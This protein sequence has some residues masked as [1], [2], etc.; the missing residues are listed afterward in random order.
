MRA[1]E[2]I[3]PLRERPFRLLLV[4]R[5]TS[6]LGDQIA[7]IAL[8]FAVLDLTGSASD[9]G[10]ALAARTLALVVFVLAG[11]VW[12]DRLSRHRLMMASDLGRLASQGL[13][14]ALLVGGIA[15]IWEV[16]ALQAVNGAATAFFRPAATGLTPATVA[17]HDV[18]RANALLTFTDSASQ[19]LGPVVAGVLVVSLGPGWGIAADAATFAVSALCLGGIR[20]PPRERTGARLSFL[21]DLRG[22]WDAVRSRTWLWLSTLLFAMFQ[23]L[24]LPT[25]FVLGPVISERDLGGAAAWAA[26]TAA[27]GAG[28]VV[29]AIGA[30][31]IRFARPL[32]ACNLTASLVVPAMVFLAAGSSTVVVAAA[33]VGAGI[34]I[35]YA[36]VI[37]ET[38]IQQSVPE[39]VL[40]RVAAYDWMGSTALRPLGY[41]AVGPIAA[42]VGTGA[43]LSFAGALTAALLIG[44]IS[45]PAIRDLRSLPVAT[46][47]TLRPP[48]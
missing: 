12:A 24:V 25:F 45:I 31:A 41:A 7:P 8:A 46:E 36:S 48:P 40:S 44:S 28:A 29:G 39:A 9:L 33:A 11:G 1:R 18:Q 20:L 34:A 16:V 15:R 26:I 4:A 30:M 17:A 23:L 43:T 37:Y 3:G 22:G 14:A 5:A 21:A 47:P 35:S 2:A 19:V 38:V 32:V 10:L 27:W 6:L 42:V 13:L